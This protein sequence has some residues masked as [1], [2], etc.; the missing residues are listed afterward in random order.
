MYIFAS[1]M[2]YL[3]GKGTLDECQSMVKEVIA[4]GEVKKHL[5]KE[6]WKPRAVMMR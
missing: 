6:W 1:N 5:A 3:A 2:L 4:N